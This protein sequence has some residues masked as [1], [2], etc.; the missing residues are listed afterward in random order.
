MTDSVCSAIDTGLT[1]IDVEWSWDGEKRCG[2]T[3]GTMASDKNQC[4]D[5][6]T[7]TNGFQPPKMTPKGVVSCWLPA[8]GA[9]S[10][11]QTGGVVS[12]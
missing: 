6:C 9:R 4:L 10:A 11:D 7:G 2:F 12:A 8:K 5:A 3:S 1:A